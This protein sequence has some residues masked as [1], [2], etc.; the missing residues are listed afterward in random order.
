MKHYKSTAQL[1]DEMIFYP[2]T[3]KDFRAIDA[4]L[5]Y[6]SKY[7]KKIAAQQS[8]L[9]PEKAAAMKAAVKAYYYKDLEASRAAVK[10]RVAKH[11]AAKKAA[12]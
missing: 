11:R 10:A 3:E 12:L 8:R 4:H 6:A 2:A 9:N 1:I 5:D 7:D